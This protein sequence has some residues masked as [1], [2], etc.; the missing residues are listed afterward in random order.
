MN[1]K[2][3]IIVTTLLKNK[4]IILTAVKY[5]QGRVYKEL[6]IFSV[7]F[8]EDNKIFFFPLFVLLPLYIYWKNKDKSF[9]SLLGT[10]IRMH[11]RSYS[12][13][14]KGALSRKK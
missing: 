9:Y 2:N 8:R 10:C 6:V 14:K 7:V 5:A 1:L 3:N 11:G 12:S 13:V 4:G